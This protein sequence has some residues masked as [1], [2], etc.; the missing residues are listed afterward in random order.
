MTEYPLLFTFRDVIVGNCFVAG[1]EANGRA[2]MVEEREG[3]FWLYGIEP[4][5][6]A[7]SGGTFEEAYA[8]YRD[9][10][11][12]ALYDIAHEATDFDAFKAEVEAYYNSTPQATL[13]AWEGAVVRVRAGEV[14]NPGLPRQSADS[15]RGL[16]VFEARLEPGAN[17]TLLAPALV[18]PDVAG[19]G[20]LAA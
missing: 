14:E 9:N 20:Q 10:H 12:L 15:P 2:L 19:E 3:E 5:A 7:G 6:I 13:K 4:G 1:V 8:D 11:R 17:E 18:R 16:K